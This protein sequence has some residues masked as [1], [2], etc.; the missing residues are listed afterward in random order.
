MDWKTSALRIFNR[1]GYGIYRIG[2]RNEYTPCPPYDY[3]TYSP[4]FEPWFREVYSKFADHTMVSED[5]CYVIYKLCLHCMHLEG[6]FAECGVYRGGTA[7]L[8]AD[9]LVCKS[10]KNKDVH[11]F[12]TF[13]GMPAIANHDPSGVKEGW[14]GDNSLSAV[15]GYLRTF[16][17]VV[18]HPGVIPETLDAV[19]DKKFAF[20]H[21]DVDLYQT[22]KD[23]CDFF[24]DR[25]QYCGV[26]IFDDYGFIPFSRSAKRAVDEFFKD[27]PES[28]LSLH[29]GQCVVI[30][31]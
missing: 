15:K 26:M 27:K 23:C 31:L 8:I 20:V 9:T 3:W 21:I 13:T 30:K 17:N 16:S 18:F 14:F 28:P 10:I 7:Y 25:M 29:T 2:S 12:D 4:W 11:L 22:A 5:R 1:M 24:Y 19:K 6:D